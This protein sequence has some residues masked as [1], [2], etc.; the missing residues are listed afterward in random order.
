MLIQM[1]DHAKIQRREW[2]FCERDLPLALNKPDS[3]ARILGDL[4]IYCMLSCKKHIADFKQNTGA[5]IR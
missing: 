3:L 4:K 1:S 5:C 2:H